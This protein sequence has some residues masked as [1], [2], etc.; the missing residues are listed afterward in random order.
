LQENYQAIQRNLYNIPQFNK[1][2]TKGKPKDV[3]MQLVGLA[4]TSTSRKHCE[5]EPQSFSHC[6]SFDHPDLQLLNECIFL[7]SFAVAN[8]NFLGHVIHRW[9]GIF[10]TFPTV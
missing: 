8:S 4:N 9:K 7:F 5:K 2:K 1:R 3:N 6:G 10:K